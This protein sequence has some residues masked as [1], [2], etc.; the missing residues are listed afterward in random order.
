MSNPVLKNTVT[1]RF[2]QSENSLGVM[3]ISGVIS[4]TAILFVVLSIFA[5]YTFSLFLK[6]FVDKAYMFCMVGII[7]GLITGLILIFS[8]SS[9][10][11]APFSM[12][13]AAFEGLTLG[14][15][16]AIFA[17]QQGGMIVVNAVFA[18]FATFLAMLFLYSTKIIKCTEK[19][20]SVVVLATFGVLIVY[21]T[22]FIMSFFNPAAN[23]VLMGSGTAGIICSVVVCI[24]AALNLII[25]F[26]MIENAQKLGLSKDFEWYGGF[27]LMVTIVWLYLEI[28]KL[29]AKTNSRR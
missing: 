19:F 5:S 14:G 22:T 10:I 12:V 18:T 17:A 4:K 26:D 8:K 27:A 7:G 9:K 11:L 23:S 29:L 28:L 16:S 2:G 20:R 24:I 15:I 25:D 13:Y 1:D 3:K 21:V 6:G